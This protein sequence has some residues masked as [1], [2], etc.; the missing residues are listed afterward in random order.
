M[1]PFSVISLFVAVAAACG[2]NAYRCTGD[3]SVSQD[4]AKT[5]HCCQK[6]SQDTCYCSHMAE[7]YCDPD[8]NNIQK[9]KDCCG[10]FK[11]YTAREC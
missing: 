5:N 11:G 7:T 10:N 9:F 1:K 2:D 8:S 6:L 4:W 3:V